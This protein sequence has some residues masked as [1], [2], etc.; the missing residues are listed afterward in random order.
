M[1]KKKPDAHRSAQPRASRVLY[2]IV[3]PPVLH[4]HV[5]RVDGDNDIDRGE[6]DDDDDDEEEEVVCEEKYVPLIY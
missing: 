4:N 1:F 2:N 6:D 5:P 3:T